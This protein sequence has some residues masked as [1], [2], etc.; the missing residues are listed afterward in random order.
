MVI[1]RLLFHC[2]INEDVE[3]LPDSPFSDSEATERSLH[4]PIGWDWGQLPEDKNCLVVPGKHFS[5]LSIEKEVRS[6]RAKKWVIG[7]VNYEK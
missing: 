1:T 4:S 3:S 6:R 5:K 7:C 2:S